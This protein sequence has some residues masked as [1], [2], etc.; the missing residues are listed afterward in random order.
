MRNS[1]WLPVSWVLWQIVK[2]LWLFDAPYCFKMVKNIEIDFL[3][4]EN[5]TGPYTVPK[6]LT[7]D[8]LTSTKRLRI[9]WNLKCIEK[10]FFC[11]FISRS[12]EKNDMNDS[13]LSPIEW[14][15]DV[16]NSNSLMVEL[17]NSRLFWASEPF[18]FSI[19]IWI[20]I[21]RDC[22]LDPETSLA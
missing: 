15:W 2:S 17:K 14:N 6:E 7:I 3:I 21:F 13:E 11:Y 18:L 8:E 22:H 12:L 19:C 20:S 10:V 16:F 5:G 9:A 4:S 1:Y